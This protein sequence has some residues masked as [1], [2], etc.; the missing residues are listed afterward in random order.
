MTI[1]IDCLGAPPKSGGME[2][3]ASELISNW[4]VSPSHPVVAIGSREL[5]K[6]VGSDQV[7]WISFPNRLFFMRI[8][9]Q[10]VMT[11]V[12]ATRF[13]AKHVLSINAVVSPLIPRRKATVVVHDWRHVFKP[14]E[15]SRSQRFY[16][17][18][19]RWSA[20]RV[21]TVVAD[22]T[23]TQSETAAIL[24]RND[25]VL[26]SPGRDHPSNW[27]YDDSFALPASP[28]VVTFGQHSNKRPELLVQ[29]LKLLVNHKDLSVVVVG[30]DRQNDLTGGLSVRER[31][32]VLVPGWVTSPQ[33]NAILRGSSA[34]ALLSSDEGFGLPVV[35]AR[36]FGIP[37]VVTRD[38][39]LADIHDAVIVCDPSPEDLAAKLDSMHLP[40]KE[41][42]ALR[43]T[44]G[45][46][47]SWK[48]ADA[49]RAIFELVT[50]EQ[51]LK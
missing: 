45:D 46:E 9:G 28:Y 8:F 4:P 47:A 43:A 15:F 1:L 41:G 5:S 37:A 7:T 27:E 29:A 13:R 31:S 38:S 21:R 3:Y 6:R 24:G 18:V 44:A 42:R 19:W 33:Y 32:R 11:P 35:E 48:W 14:A 17:R 23:K 20:K 39:G 22:S 30:M 26:V 51:A 49:S 10:F 12:V 2:L 36:Y 34:V 40:T 25:V 50:G 16:R